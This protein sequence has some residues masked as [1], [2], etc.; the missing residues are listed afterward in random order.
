MTMI[1]QVSPPPLP[2]KQHIRRQRHDSHYDNVPELLS[3]ILQSSED[4]DDT[5][6][7]L[8]P[9]KKHSKCKLTKESVGNK[10]NIRIH[11]ILSRDDFYISGE[12]LKT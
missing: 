9:K 4:N 11:C 6:P 10:Y 1:F 5:P 12:S 2:D 7:P 8:P 3:S